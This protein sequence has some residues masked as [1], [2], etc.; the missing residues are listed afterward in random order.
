[1]LSTLSLRDTPSAGDITYTVSPQCH[2]TSPA[3][4]EY[5]VI[6]TE[7]H[8]FSRMTS[9]TVCHYTAIIILSVD[10]GYNVTEGHISCLTTSDMHTVCHHTV[11]AIS[12]FGTGYAGT[13]TGRQIFSTET[14][15]RLCHYTNTVTSSVDAGS[16]DNTSLS[17][18][19]SA[20]FCGTWT[21]D[22]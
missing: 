14:P 2:C 19:T 18:M 1:M 17:R 5:T 11:S 10:A 8:I 21:V 9:Y 22:K 20:T 13:G 3:D 7:G 4:A 12:S 15:H 16:K 6:V